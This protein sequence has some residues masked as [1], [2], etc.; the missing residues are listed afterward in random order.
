MVREKPEVS[1]NPLHFFPA[2]DIHEP[3]SEQVRMAVHG[4]GSEGVGGTQT[5]LLRHGK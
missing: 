2:A 5:T 4:Q 3:G 1:V